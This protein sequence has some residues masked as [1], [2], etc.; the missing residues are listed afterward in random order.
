MKGKTRI[1]RARVLAERRE[2]RYQTCL[3]ML[4]HQALEKEGRRLGR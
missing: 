3:K 1:Y 4:L 2:L